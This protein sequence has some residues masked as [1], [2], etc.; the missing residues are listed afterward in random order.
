MSHIYLLLRAKF[1]LPIPQVCPLALVGIQDTNIS[2]VQSRKKGKKWLALPLADPDE[3]GVRD[4]NELQHYT[5]QPEEKKENASHARVDLSV[6]EKAVETSTGKNDFNC[7]RV[8]TPVTI[9]NPADMSEVELAKLV[10]P[11]TSKR[12]STLKARKVGEKKVGPLERKH[13]TS[14]LREPP[15]APFI[16]GTV[17]DREHFSTLPLALEG[18]GDFNRAREK[19]R[20]GAGISGSNENN[21]DKG[22][23]SWKTRVSSVTTPP[24]PREHESSMADKELFSSNGEFSN[25]LDLFYSGIDCSLEEGETTSTSNGYGLVRCPQADL[26]D[27]E[28]LTSRFFFIHLWKGW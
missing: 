21:F 13:A 10:G 6:Q 27:G 19:V 28:M 9:R 18:A 8:S 5:E 17:P 16:Q 22:S 3:V 7:R 11:T 25:I 24:T 26:V 2:T 12:Q 20:D 23:T 1:P 14:A 15:I 4:Y